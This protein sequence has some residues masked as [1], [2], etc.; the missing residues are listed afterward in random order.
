[1]FLYIKVFDQH[2]KERARTD[3]NKIRVSE[4]RTLLCEN[5]LFQDKDQKSREQILTKK[6]KE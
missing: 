5:M 2:S 6:L 4:Q 3:R 1:M